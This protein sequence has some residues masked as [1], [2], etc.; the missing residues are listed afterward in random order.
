[1]RGIKGV[2]VLTRNTIEATDVNIWQRNTRVSSSGYQVLG[3]GARGARH[4]RYRVTNKSSRPG[5]R[6]TR[7][8]TKRR[9]QTKTHDNAFL[10]PGY[11]HM[12]L[13]QVEVDQTTHQKRRS[14]PNQAPRLIGKRTGLDKVVVRR[15]PKDIDQLGAVV[16]RWHGRR[17]HGCCRRTMD[18]W[19]RCVRNEDD[20]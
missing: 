16:D 17:R 11:Q 4:T 15:R 1:M 3:F 12:S 5:M 20:V 2:D 10:V 19:Q 7:S 8:R 9:R 6:T 14:K 18:M 13:C